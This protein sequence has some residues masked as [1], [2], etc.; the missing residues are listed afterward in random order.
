DQLGG[1]HDERAAADGRRVDDVAVGIED[2]LAR[3]ER[4]GAE[5]AHG[6]DAAREE[7]LEQRQL[8]AAP[9]LVAEAPADAAAG[10]ADERAERRA[11]VERIEPARASFDL[12]EVALAAEA[13]E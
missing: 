10:G 4:A 12:D 1:E 3:P 9:P 2:R 13:G 6:V 8:L 7:A 11:L 5:S